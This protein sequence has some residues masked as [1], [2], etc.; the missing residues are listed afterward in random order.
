M[1]CHCRM[2]QRASGGPYVAYAA[3]EPSSLRW[4]HGNPGRYRSSDRAERLYCRACGTPL[5]FRNIA[6]GTTDLTAGS[7]DNPELAR[8]T[9]ALGAESKRSWVEHITD[10]PERTTAE[11]LAEKGEGM[12]QPIMNIGREGT[13]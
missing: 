5:A 9:W 7:L 6:R 12:P 8:P 3:P 2:C 4:T 13:D 1:I 10:L 11:W